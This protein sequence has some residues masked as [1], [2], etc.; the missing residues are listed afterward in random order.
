MVEDAKGC[1]S[2]PTARIYEDL[3]VRL[4]ASVPK[5]PHLS[6][7]YEIALTVSTFSFQP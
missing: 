6:L 2:H 5:Q 3:R 7:R 1:L 4:C